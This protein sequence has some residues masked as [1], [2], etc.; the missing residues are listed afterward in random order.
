[1]RKYGNGIKVKSHDEVCRRHKFQTLAIAH[2]NA[3]NVKMGLAEGVLDIDTNEFDK[4]AGQFNY[5]LRCLQ[6]WMNK[7]EKRYSEQFGELASSRAD[8]DKDGRITKEIE[9]LLKKGFIQNF[10]R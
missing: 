4:W 6:G 1:M 5:T 2:M 3:L 7:D 9:G 10:V 8:D